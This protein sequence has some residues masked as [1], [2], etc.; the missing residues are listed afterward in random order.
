MASRKTI[1]SIKEIDDWVKANSR[2][3]PSTGGL[4]P[5]SN[6]PSSLPPPINNWQIYATSGSSNDCMIHALLIDC[7]P[8]FRTLLDDNKNTVARE[9]RTGPFLRI[10]LKYYN[11]DPRKPVTRGGVSDRPLVEPERTRFLQ[12]LI[13]SQDFLREEFLEPISEH[14]NFNILL[15]SL[16]P[17]TLP[18]G[19]VPLDPVPANPTIVMYNPSSVHFSAMSSNSDDFFLDTSEIVALKARMDAT[20]F[21]STR[22]NCEYNHGDAFLLNG[23]TFIIDTPQSY[24]DTPMADGSIVAQCISVNIQNTNTGTLITNVPTAFLYR[25]RTGEL[26]FN[27]KEYEEYRKVYN[28]RNPGRKEQLQPLIDSPPAPSSSNPFTP[29]PLKPRAPTSAPPPP[30]K[31]RAIPELFTPPA[32]PKPCPTGTAAA[33]GTGFSETLECAVA[34]PPAPGTITSFWNQKIIETIN[35]LKDARHKELMKGDDNTQP[36]F[37]N[38][39]EFKTL[40]LDNTGK[41]IVPTI[42]KDR[43]RDYTS[44]E[45]EFNQVM[46]VLQDRIEQIT[47]FKA[48]IEIDNTFL[49]ANNQLNILTSMLQYPQN[50]Q[51]ENY[52]LIANLIQSRDTTNIVSNMVGKRTLKLPLKNYINFVA[53][54]VLFSRYGLE[55][56]IL[57][58]ATALVTTNKWKELYSDLFTEFSDTD[59]KNFGNLSTRILTVFSAF[60]TKNQNIITDSFITKLRDGTYMYEI[61]KNGYENAELLQ[62][63]AAKNVSGREKAVAESRQELKTRKSQFALSRQIIQERTRT[64]LETPFPDIRTIPTSF[65]FD[66]YTEEEKKFMIQENSICAEIAELTGKLG[67]VNV[68]Q[69]QIPHD[70]FIKESKENDKLASFLEETGPNVSKDILSERRRLFFEGRGPFVGLSGGGGRG[71]GRKTKRLKPFRIRKKTKNN[72]KT[73]CKK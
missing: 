31:T 61:Y 49:L 4:S 72:R 42:D 70:F 65:I 66:R 53:L 24:Q 44:N 43:V 8:H 2:S 33:K 1:N 29:P 47:I 28:V 63:N 23:I 48:N 39:P 40:E 14:Y 51:L 45:A 41:V 52:F 71:R 10:V 5:Y 15:R 25:N 46:K 50:S 26:S 57:K 19:L 37:N 32:P 67:K 64:W 38:Y 58:K 30:G 54:F 36:I 22:R 59:D 35:I 56:G 69:M 13:E 17:D 60:L 11:N 3:M 7:S 9:F 21:T 12:D 68:P 62:D 27:N 20:T 6:P 16:K 34:A 55:D 18:F 73:R